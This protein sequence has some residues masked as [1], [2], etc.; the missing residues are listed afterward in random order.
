MG[1]SLMGSSEP[2]CE[3]C[4]LASLRMSSYVSVLLRNG[5]WRAIRESGGY[6]RCQGQGCQKCGGRDDTNLGSHGSLLLAGQRGRGPRHRKDLSWVR[7]VLL[8]FFPTEGPAASVKASG[9]NCDDVAL[10]LVSRRTR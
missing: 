7:Q 3:G 8:T 5:T 2:P 10:R 1:R 9:R 4:V 6:E